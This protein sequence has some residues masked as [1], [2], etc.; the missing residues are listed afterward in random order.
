MKTLARP[1]PCPRPAR[2]RPE[3]VPVTVAPRLLRDL[4]PARL[5]AWGLSLALS[6]VMAPRAASAQGVVLDG[7]TEAVLTTAAPRF[8]VRALGVP[9]TAR[10]LHF[11]LYITRNS[12]GDSPYHDQVDVDS[13]DSIASI[14]V[15]RLLPPSAVV[16]W[17]A[18]V[19]LPDGRIFESAI[20]GPRQVAPWLTLIS[21][22]SPLGDQ[23]DTR[24][25]TFVWKSPKVDASIGPWTYELQILNNGRAEVVAGSLTDTV[26]TP[27]RELQANAPYRWQVRASVKTGESVTERNLATFLVV[28]RALPTTTLLYKNFPNPFPSPAAFATCF[29]FDVGAGGARVQ[30]D[31]VDLR[32]NLIRTIIANETFAAGAYGRGPS[33]SGNNCDNRFVWNGTATNGITVPAGVYLARFVA[34]GSRPSFTKML[35][36]G[37]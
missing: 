25:P 11:T 10:P 6:L 37:R 34:N 22:N 17:K 5:L 33:G 29:W 21:P 31:V 16:F 18:R 28:D 24:R 15:T 1:R 35:F 20:A 13:P 23:F 32:G 2:L 26:Y 3:R 30:L 7:P 19:T 14:A 36:L 12:T 4:A 9:V 27:D 8:T